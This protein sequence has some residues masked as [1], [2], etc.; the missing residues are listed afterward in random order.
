MAEIRT[1]LVASA[2]GMIGKALMQETSSAAG[3][4]ARPFG[5][6]ARLG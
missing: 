1:A 5:S 4:H 6:A 3:W 2:N